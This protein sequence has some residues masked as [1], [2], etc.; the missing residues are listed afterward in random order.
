[1]KFGLVLSLIALSAA[2]HAQVADNTGANAGAGTAFAIPRVNAAYPGIANVTRT[3]LTQNS[4]V[5][6][7]NFFISGGVRL[8]PSSENRGGR[9][10]TAAIAPQSTRQ[11]AAL[12]HYRARL[13]SEKSLLEDALS[14]TPHHPSAPRARVRVAQL[15]HLMQNADRQIAALQPPPSPPA[16]TPE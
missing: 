4:S 11:I 9:I 8:E 16:V 15:D 14:K 13:N 5:I 12:Q 2:S 6:A 7:R 10:A 3:N 1:M